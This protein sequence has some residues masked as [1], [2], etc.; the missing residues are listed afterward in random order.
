MYLV[1]SPYRIYC[2]SVPAINYNFSS[3]SLQLLHAKFSY[4]CTIRGLERIVV[5]EILG[6]DRLVEGR[7]I[8]IIKNYVEGRIIKIIKNYVLYFLHSSASI[9]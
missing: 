6:S 9:D 8:K 2:T 7:I 3:Y 1:S 4:D 5:H